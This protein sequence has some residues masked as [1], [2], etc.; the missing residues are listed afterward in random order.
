MH[1]V[2]LY[3]DDARSLGEKWAEFQRQGLLGTGIWTNAFEGT[4]G[5][6]TTALRKAWLTGG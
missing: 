1:W 4:S 2:Q 5:D 6:L 3:Y